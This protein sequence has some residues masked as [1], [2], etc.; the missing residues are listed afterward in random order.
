[1]RYVAA[2]VACLALLLIFAFL[3]VAVFASVE[4][5]GAIP[6]LVLFALMVLTWRA[7]VKRRP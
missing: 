1:M 7:I 3:R 2:I 6:L 5:P 4:Q